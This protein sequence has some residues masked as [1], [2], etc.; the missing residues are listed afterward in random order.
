MFV[1][2][3]SLTTL[4]SHPTMVLL[5]LLLH[6]SLWCLQ[7][8]EWLILD[9]YF[10][11]THRP[12]VEHHAWTNLPFLYLL[13]SKVTTHELFCKFYTKG[14]NQFNISCAII[15]YFKIL[16]VCLMIWC[17][18]LEFL[19]SLPKCSSSM[20]NILLL[21]SS[22]HQTCFSTALLLLNHGCASLLFSGLW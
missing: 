21:C 14:L 13:A 5:I 7:S 22:T 3:M 8:G 4:F 12:T 9:S 16:C 10:P 1:Q 15:F 20:L 6:L 17:L 19:Y 11:Y 2:S 18:F